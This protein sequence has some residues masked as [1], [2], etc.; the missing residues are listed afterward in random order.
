M[1]L[2]TGDT[3]FILELLEAAGDIFFNGTV[4]RDKAV[5]FYRVR[6]TFL[7]HTRDSY[8]THS[9]CGEVYMQETYCI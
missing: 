7:L 9:L 4:E 3:Q 2:S 8:K 5:C 1:G 6:T